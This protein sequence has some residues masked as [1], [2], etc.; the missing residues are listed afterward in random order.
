VK[1]FAE[2]MIKDHQQFAEQLQQ[3]AIKGGYSEQQ[4]TLSGAERKPESPATRNRS[5]TR[6]PGTAQSPSDRRAADRS[7]ARPTELDPSRSGTID[8]IGLKQELAEQCLQSSREA[9]EKEDQARFDMHYMGAQI[10]AHQGMIDMLT[11]FARHA[12]PELQQTLE[13]GRQTAEQHLE[14]ARQIKDELARASGAQ[15]QQAERERP[16]NN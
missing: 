2:M 5:T 3:I 16:A 12:T 11:V 10:M 15:P 13:Q 4:L 6:E 8:F 14:K 7:T 1:Q 9:L